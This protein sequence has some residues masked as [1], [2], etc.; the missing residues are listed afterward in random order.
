VCASRRNVRSSRR[1]SESCSRRGPTSIAAD[2]AASACSDAAGPADGFDPV[3][4]GPGLAVVPAVAPED[5][6]PGLGA[7]STPESLGAHPASQGTASVGAA[8][9][10]PMIVRRVHWVGGTA[11]ASASESATRRPYLSRTVC[12]PT[13]AAR[14]VLQIGNA[15]TEGPNRI[16]GQRHEREPDCWCAD[17]DPCPV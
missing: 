11:P 16:E 2:S 13:R 9:P 10:K 5:A 15:T 7:L 17:P 14:D 6:G 1:S 12:C 8:R 4:V 3:S